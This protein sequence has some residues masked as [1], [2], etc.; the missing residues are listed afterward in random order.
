MTRIRSFKQLS[1]VGLLTGAMTFSFASVNVIA[2]QEQ[3]K[4][5][6][7]AKEEPKKT[8]GASKGAGATDSPSQDK[9]KTAEPGAGKPTVSLQPLSARPMVAKPNT[10]NVNKPGTGIPEP[11][12][13]NKPGEVPAIKF[14]TPNYDFGK[15]K[16]GPPIEHDYWF[17]NTGNGILEILAVRPSC[18]CTTA[19]DFDKVVKPGQTGKIPIRIGSEH[20]SGPI[21]K[22]VTV[23]TNAPAAEASI[24]LQIKGEVWQA[25]QVTPQMAS[26]GRI[27]M[28]QIQ[29]GVS[30]K[31]TIQNNAAEPLKLSDIKLPKDSGYVAELKTLEEGKKYELEV[32]ATSLLKLGDNHATVEISTNSTETPKVSV[33]IFSFLSK[34]VDVS[35]EELVLV[36]NRTTDLNRQFYI[37]VNTNKDVKISDMKATNPEFKLSLEEVTKGKLFRLSCI[38]PTKYNPT[39]GDQIT[40]KTDHPLVP[41]ISIPVSQSM[42]AAPAPNMSQSVSSPSKAGTKSGGTIQPQARRNGI[43][44]RR[45]QK[46]GP[47]TQDVNKA[48]TT[49][50]GATTGD[51]AKTTDEKSGS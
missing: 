48:G 42:I 24:T 13:K 40:F 38:V 44:S 43:S 41:T 2:Q 51:K 18:G 3:K 4:T 39:K 10:A 31:V 17:T 5:D 6:A 25:V 23:Q 11:T 1:L 8:E 20:I 49:P 14:D 34:P 32:K 7:A 9:T 15:I 47:G 35:P 33:A 16:A 50:A 29:E 22:S 30:S 19:G 36:P 27:S 26:L 45:A 28:E 12:V 46:A 37:R 21:T